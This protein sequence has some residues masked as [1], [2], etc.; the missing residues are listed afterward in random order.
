MTNVE[1]NFYEKVPVILAKIG[2]QLE[3]LED[4]IVQ[5]RELKEEISFHE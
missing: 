4:I 5:L 1:Q 3:M 2:S